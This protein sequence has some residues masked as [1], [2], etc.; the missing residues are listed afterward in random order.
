MRKVLLVEDNT[1]NR[2]VYSTIL[3]HVGYEVIEA[4]NGEEGVKLA[5]EVKPDI[6]LMDMSLPK[7][8]GWQATK[9]IKSNKELEGIP[10]ICLPGVPRELEY[11]MKKEVIPWITAKFSIKGRKIV[12]SV[13]KT[14]GIGEGSDDEMIRE[15]MGE[16]KNPEV[17][18]LASMGEIK[19]RVTASAESEEEARKK[20][21]PVEKGI[22]SVLGDSVFGRDDDTLEGVIEFKPNHEF[23]TGKTQ[24]CYNRKIARRDEKR[25]SS[26]SSIN[27]NGVYL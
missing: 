2:E 9:L 25:S 3:R 22:C 1:D 27:G 5:E 15:Y 10:V 14:V 26:G 11:L 21:L 16:G 23:R 8:D 19:I 7:L 6:I 17:G 12:Y 13:L 4:V 18:L 24:F 20:I